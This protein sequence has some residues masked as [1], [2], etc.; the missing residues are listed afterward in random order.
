M[1]L[2]HKNNLSVYSGVSKQASELRLDTHCEEMI[3]CYPSIPYGVRRRNPTKLISNLVSVEPDQFLYT[4]DR[5]LSGESEEQYVV[6][7]DKTNGLKV[8]DIQ[9][10]EYRTVT[11]TGNAE[12]YLTSSNPEIGFS[13]IT[14]KDTTF[15]ANKD[16]IPSRIGESATAVKYAKL[17]LN[18]AGYTSGY[19][20]VASLVTKNISINGSSTY[21]RSLG[22]STLSSALVGTTSS[23]KTSLAPARY[24][25]YKGVYGTQTIYADT[26]AGAL[27]N[28]TVDG[29]LLTYNVK[30]KSDGLN[31]YPETM[32]ELKLN[33]YSFL[34]EQLSPTLY[35]TSLDAN[36][37]IIIQKID[38][39]VV[40]VTSS[41]T[42]PSS[43]DATPPALQKISYIYLYSALTYVNTPV[44]WTVFNE[45]NLGGGVITSIP[46]GTGSIDYVVASDY[47]KKAFVWIQ[48][49]SVDT[50]F[51]YT[52]YVTL[53]ETNGTT[54]AST[55]SNATTT[56]GVATA[57]S[58]WAT[59]LADFTGVVDGSIVRITRDSGAEFLIT[60]SDTY[61][62]QASSAWKG[63]V[64]QISDMPKHF[65]F[66][67]T[68]V[69]IDGVSS[70][71][72]SAYWVR[73]DGNQWV[74]WRDPN[75]L[76]IIN[77]TTMPH[78][79]V[80]N[81][82]FTFTLSTIDWS[83]MLVGDE[84]SQDI[85]Q[86]IG[87]SIQDLFFVNGRLGILTRNG[88]SLSQQEVFNNFFRTTVLN[89]LDDS[90]I[91]TYIDSSKSV[92]LR[93]A[94]ELQGSIILFGDKMQFALDASKPISPSTISVRPIS[95]F[96]INKNV[97]PITSGDSVF[98][99]VE[100]NSYSSLYEM[101]QV[102][103]SNSIR[104]IDVSA[105]VPN[106]IDSDIMQIVSSYR[107]N[108][109]FLRSRTNKDTIYVYKHFGTEQQ[110]EQTAWSKWV[111]SMHIDGI[112]VFD[113]E[114]YLFGSRYDST[115][116]VDE[117]SLV[118]TWD[119]TK[120]WLDDTYWVDGELLATPSFEKLEI[121]PYGIGATFKDLATTRYNSELELSK[122]AITNSSG[123][124]E[125][126]G[127]LL[128]K[129]AE[130]A[131]NGGS[132][133]Y[134][135]VEDM[136]RQTRR[137]IPAI[138]SVDRKPFI[139]GNADNMRIKIISSNGDGFQ[140]NAISLEGQYNVRSKRV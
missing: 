139:S 120:T 56:T 67:D 43:V 2:V 48:Q 86:F 23:A 35:V 4:Y 71:D 138:Y 37:D 46:T 126:R 115:V 40:T 13:A 133:F 7:I 124:K 45:Q 85:P 127:S 31:I 94:I 9:S 92:G 135:I 111:F 98:F 131:S 41:V 113:K 44:A 22:F 70:T 78:K 121:E 69:K 81:A 122:W 108:A 30:T 65:P 15:I 105:H 132:N 21:L 27:I 3:N 125:I 64:A 107:D 60:V 82:D 84:D 93:Y 99:L 72:E 24:K 61:G 109:I 110:K 103:I 117:F 68:V 1:A 77:P 54:I 136:E 95:G 80:R 25:T 128:I 119:D 38:G 79:L 89:L 137:E 73:Y 18:S 100:N 90:A 91:T 106:Y 55:S 6:T 88:I 29:T 87:N 34:S 33:I 26:C 14:I 20:T 53:K 51:P 17:T 12:S 47:N 129:T 140:I 50:A 10:G 8:F 28:I 116:P 59:G 112:F 101:N 58:S 5:G 57:I 11:H 16:I 62:N 123:Q 75:M 130:I 83:Q 52:F 63:S 74:E 118:G 76:S 66:K 134:L 32:A 36:G 102:T 97:K 96:E 42:I 19:N 39:T 104:A 114:L 49:V